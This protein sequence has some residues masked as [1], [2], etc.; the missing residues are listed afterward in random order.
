MQY[1]FDICS[2]FPTVFSDEKV[3]YILKIAASRQKPQK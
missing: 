2:N 3:H 1:K